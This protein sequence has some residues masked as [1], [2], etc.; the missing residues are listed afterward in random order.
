[1]PKLLEVVLLW[2]QGCMLGSPARP[3]KESHG[4]RPITDS[5]AMTS[6]V[7]GNTSQRTLESARYAH[8]QRCVNT[9]TGDVFKLKKSYPS[10]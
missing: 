1:L 9:G 7:K 10:C 2:V 8:R 5:T 6:M 3:R 4:L